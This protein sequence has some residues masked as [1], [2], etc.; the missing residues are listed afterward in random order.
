[1]LGIVVVMR[2]LTDAD[3]IVQST[4]KIMIQK[5]CIDTCAKLRKCFVDVWLTCQNV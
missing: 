2:D 3:D 4:K 5:N 1:M